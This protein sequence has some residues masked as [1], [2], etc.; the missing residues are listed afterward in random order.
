MNDDN[1]CLPI[2]ISFIIIFL[3]I[4]GTN[5]CSSGAWNYGECPN[6]DIRYELRGVSKGLKYYVCPECGK[7]VE[8]Y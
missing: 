4:F 1:G 3:I 2:I 8:R 7:E 5:T 6:C